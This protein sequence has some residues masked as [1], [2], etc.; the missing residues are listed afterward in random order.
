MSNLSARERAAGILSGHKLRMLENAG[1]VVMDK[2]RA[3]ALEKLRNGLHDK[4]NKR[5]RFEATACDEAIK[6]LIKLQG[7]E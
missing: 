5:P 6:T 2:Q 7:D 4:E 1:I 3:D